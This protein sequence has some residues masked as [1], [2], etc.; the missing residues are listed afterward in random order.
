MPTPK[1]PASNRLL[2][3]LPPR[4][5]DEFIAACEH[6]DLNFEET[7]VKPGETLQH[8]YF[9]LRGYISQ[10]TPVDRSSIEVG[11]IGNE[12]MLGVQLALGVTK[13]PMTSLVQGQGEAL[14]MTYR[15]FRGELEKNG[16]MRQEV[17]RY[18]F[19]VM[20]QMARN[21]GC[22]RFH[23]VES[24][25]ARWL[26]M[27]ADR[28]HANVFNITQAFLAYMLGVRRVGVTVAA[29]NLQARG[30]IRSLRGKVEILDLEGLRGAA[31]SCYRADLAIYRDTLG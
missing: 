12:G 29:G 30:L 24:R 9:P 22:N 10:I 31:C 11:L 6:V 20:S 23:V 25:L 15:A 1:R 19:V 2:A 18:T 8:V 26:A 5:R 14:R 28:A 17:N 3:K 27:T 21:A 7:L 4:Y 13:A 16:L